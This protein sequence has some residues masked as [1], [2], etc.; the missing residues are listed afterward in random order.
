[1]IKT[2]YKNPQSKYW[3]DFI[4]ETENV[5]FPSSGGG[6]FFAKYMVNV[7]NKFLNTTKGKNLGEIKLPSLGSVYGLSGKRRFR[8][9]LH[10]FNYHSPGVIYKY[11][12]NSKKSEIYWEPEIEFRS[13]SIFKIVSLNLPTEQRFYDNYSQKELN[14]MV[15]PTLWIWWF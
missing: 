8:S 4:P 1:M 10:S 5:L 9:I 11:N 2:N 3:K 7:V 12:V 6:Y 15:K 13:S 14:M